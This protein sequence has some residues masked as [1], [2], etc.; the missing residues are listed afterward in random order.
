MKNLIWTIFG[1]LVGVVFAS[2]THILGGPSWAV[3]LTWI[4]TYNGWM[5]SNVDFR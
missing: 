2:I 1:F 3:W 5:Q 4:V